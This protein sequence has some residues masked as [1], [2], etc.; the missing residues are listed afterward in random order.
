MRVCEP[1][2]LCVPPLILRAMTTGRVARSAGLLSGG[3]SGWRTQVS[4][5]P[6]KYPSCQAYPGRDGH[7]P[8]EAPVGQAAS[9]LP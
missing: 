8:F 1:C 4:N 2:G 6:R 3:T 9:R 5:L 7:L